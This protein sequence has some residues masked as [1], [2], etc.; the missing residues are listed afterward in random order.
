M[1]D[2]E[3]TLSKSYQPPNRKLIA[4]DL[5]SVIHNQ[6]MVRKLVLIKK[7]SDIFGLLFLGD[8][9]TISRAP[10]LKNLVPGK[11]CQWPY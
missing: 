8:G 2:L 5:L 4:K 6:N 1:L 3:I 11:I 7:E 9:A 10:L